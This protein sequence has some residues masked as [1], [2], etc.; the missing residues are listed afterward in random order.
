MAELYAAVVSGRL[1]ALNAPSSA[2]WYRRLMAE[3]GL[4]EAVPVTIAVPPGS[5]AAVARVAHGLGLLFGVR[6]LTEPIGSPAPC[7][8]S[9]GA[10][11]CAVSERTF[12]PALGRLLDAQS[13]IAAGRERIGARPAR[14]YLP[15]PGPW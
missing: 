8:R 10:P 12:G 5:T 14:V 7:S 11:W 2:R 4:L 9:F 13:I 15:G 6:W 3:S 1:M